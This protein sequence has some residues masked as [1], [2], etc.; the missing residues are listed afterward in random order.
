MV[1]FPRGRTVTDH[2]SA[3]PDTEALTAE[4]IEAAYE[5]AL[6][7]MESVELAAEKLG[8]DADSEGVWQSGPQQ[9]SLEDRGAHDAEAVRGQ[10]VGDSSPATLLHPREIIE[11][12]LFV[13]GQ[14]LTTRR[15]GQMFGE[16]E[17]QERIDH[18]ISELNELY[19]AQQRPYQIDFGEGGYRLVLRQ[20]YETVRNAVFGAGPKDVKLSQD[21]LEVLA[22]VAYR[23]PTTLQD[24]EAAGQE[25]S[26]GLL[27]QLLRRQLITLERNDRGVVSYTTTPRFLDVFGLRSLDELPFPEDLE[28]K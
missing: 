9:V 27:R 21:A 5:R 20:E 23:Q 10:S 16:R 15:L 25:K 4:E 14:P 18:Y 2:S 11:A 7:A 28:L 6:S 1:R 12:A 3:L 19:A 17:T 22:F 24:L 13:G 8:A 26:G